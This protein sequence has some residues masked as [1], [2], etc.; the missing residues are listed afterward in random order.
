MLRFYMLKNKCN[1]Y[2]QRFFGK[3]KLKKNKLNLKK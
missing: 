2:K 3:R 1:K